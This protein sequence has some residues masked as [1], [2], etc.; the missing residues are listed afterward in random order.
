MDGSIFKTI[1][2]LQ[3]QSSLWGTPLQKLSQG[4]GSSCPINTAGSG[5]APWFPW[6]VR[7]TP[8]F[9]ANDGPCLPAAG[10]LAH[11]SRERVGE[12]SNLPSPP[13]LSSTAEAG[14]GGY[15]LSQLPFHPRD[16]PCM[17]WTTTQRS[18]KGSLHAGTV[19]ER[20]VLHGY[21]K[22]GCMVCR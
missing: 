2:S 12:D 16:Q 20:A 8:G 9:W 22:K 3:S 7:K 5:R 4:L 10:A 1:Q 6:I 14:H 15:L 13:F 21:R 11:P 17:S 19:A 18:D